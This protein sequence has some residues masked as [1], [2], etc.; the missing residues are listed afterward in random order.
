M[1]LT[2]LTRISTS[3]IATGSTIDSPILRKDVDFRGNQVG[4]TSVLFDS[5]ERELN[6]KDNVKLNFGDGEDLTLRH[7]GSSSYIENSTG[8]LF[9]HGNDIALRSQAQE[10]Y[11]VC[12][13][14]AEVELYH[15]MGGASAEKKFETTTHGAVVTGILTATGFS[16]PLSNP[17]GI[18]TFYDLRVTNN[19]TVE[20]T[21][22]TLDTNLIGVDRVEVGANSNSI[23]GVAITQSGTADLVNLFD[24][25]TKVV[26]IDDT[27]KVGIGTDAPTQ[28]IDVLKT[29][30]MAK[31]KVRTTGAGAYFEADSVSSGYLG[32]I[33]SSGG[34]ERWLMGGYA[35]NNFTIKDGS[36]A[37][38]NERFTIVDGT[39]KVGINST[40]PGE[41]L[42]VGGAILT[43]STFNNT[44]KFQHNS[45][46]FQ[47]SGSGHIDHETTNQ[48]INFRVTKSTTS[49]TTMVKIDTSAE[50][51]K[52]RKVITVGLQG[53]ADTTV[54]GG[55]SG[56][57]AYLQLNYANNSIV[58]T[59]LLGN[60]DSWLNSNYGNLGIGTAVAGKKLHVFKS[61]QH[62]VILERGD[63]ANTQIEL[64]TAGATRGYWACSD[65]ANFM[66]YDND[67]S[68][69]HFE[70]LQTG[71]VQTR[72]LGTLNLNSD[73]GAYA[74][75][76]V[77]FP[78]NDTSKWFSFVG[79]GL[80]FTDGGNFV[81]PSDDAGTNWG[82]IAG[83]AFEGSSNGS[84]PA[85]R[86]VVDEPGGNGTN[87]SLGSGNSGKT[88][89]IDNN[90]AMSINSSGRILI[91]TTSP[92]IVSTTVNPY[93]QLE[94]TDYNGS[95]LSITRNSNNEHGAYLILGKSRGTSNGADTI[96]QDNDAISE[97]RFAGSDGNDMVNIAALIRVEIDGTPQTDQMPGA[98]IF[99]TNSGGTG[100]TEA[101]RI[102]KNGNSQFGGLTSG[103]P[104][105]DTNA[106]NVIDLG[107]GTMNRGL[108]W[109]GSN[110]NYANIWTE[111]S[112]GDL[113]IATGLRMNNNSGTY[114][115][116]YGGSAIGRANIELGLNG[117]I[118]VR[119]AASGT[120]ANGT[121]VTDLEERL[122]IETNGNIYHTS[123]AGRIFSTR[124]FGEA[125]ILIGSG[126]AGG[127]TLYL[128]GDSNGDWAGGD[129]AYIRHNTSGNLDIVSTN[130]NDDGSITFNTG[131][132]TYVGQI[133]DEGVLKMLGSNNSRAIEI[134]PGGNA[135]TMVLDRNGYLT[136]MIR[137]S[138][139]GSNVAGGSGGGSRLQLAKNEIYMY[140]FPHTTSI[141]DA[142]SYSQVF[143]IDTNGN[144]HGSSSNNI[145]DQRLKKDIETVT[146]PLTKIKGLTGR[147]FK[148]KEDSTKFDDKTKYGFIAQEVET[149]I[150]ELVDTEHGIIL[151][152][153][154]DKVIYDEDAAVSRS[155]AVNETGIIP[156]TVEALKVLIS[157]VETLEAKVAALEGS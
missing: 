135:G 111:Y 102:D 100:A 48:D 131:A 17:S 73:W 77:V 18:S 104:W 44:A 3:G 41:R 93:L 138:D 78:C 2:D 65:T 57:G 109:G 7:T 152:D 86:F 151:F 11:I 126:N 36:A 76:V 124:N 105:I 89:A 149:T 92:R 98:M 16:G 119:N 95:A 120:V 24:G 58:N 88:A 141:G 71:D 118:R 136:S 112:S 115:S 146:D 5:S 63:N 137:A 128:D 42:D 28:L 37:S 4:V 150:P 43:R 47:T 113:N 127:A 15:G 62:P 153:K 155:K 114:V 61:N 75:N 19:L 90:T 145:S 79:T 40:S 142:P 121:A 33:L 68:T 64:K 84:D 94:S 46:Q 35:S 55:G 144:F 13:A 31:I 32:L 148:W 70:V 29:S 130:P 52:F 110:A 82:N 134:N 74:R 23:V 106:R 8:F 10:N 83:I 156:I 132:G 85:I 30:N 154:D 53:G 129:Y 116:S 72:G 59:K 60:G 39:G 54:I 96:L 108:G 27:G 20:G 147:T 26:A 9:I 157:K 103:G 38:G 91:G 49:D 50:Q 34:T 12:D 122:R 66:V 21:T 80:R 67:A 45:W 107:S 81:K 25:A 123:D 101:L 117:I 56:I 97:I 140:R 1:A 14:N 6:L 99:K 143:R 22:T 69:Y 133:N 125:G 139:G 51:T 87:Y